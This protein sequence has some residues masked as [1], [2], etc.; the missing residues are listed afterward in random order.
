MTLSVQQR[1]E[2]APYAPHVEV[3]TSGFTVTQTNEQG[4]G[5][6]VVTHVTLLP[7][8]MYELS[9]DGDGEAFEVDP[10]GVGYSSLEFCFAL[11]FG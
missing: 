9:S 10:A 6:K 5:E 11:T 3:A 2:A 8:G 7:S 4:G 1:L